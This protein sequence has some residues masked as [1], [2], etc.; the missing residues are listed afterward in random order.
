MFESAFRESNDP[1]NGSDTTKGKT[2]INPD[3]KDTRAWLTS[4]FGCC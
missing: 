4:G 3:R 1:V 2:V